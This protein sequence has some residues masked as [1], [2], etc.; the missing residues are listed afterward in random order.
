ISGVSGAG[1]G[2]IINGV[3]K[4]GKFNLA[5]GINVTTRPKEKRDKFDPHFQFVDIVKFK[6]MI[7]KDELLEYDF[8]HHNYYGTNRLIL[9]KLLNNHNILMEA[10]VNGALEIKKKISGVILIYIMVDLEIL[11]KRVKKRDNET[12]EEVEMRMKRAELENCKGLSF[13]YQIENPEGHPE[14]AIKR[15]LKIIK[16]ELQDR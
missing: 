14:A 6:E 5:R 15:V 7:K 3:L 9:E 4:T 12:K 10:D 11:K 1:K 13:D 16:K 8:H 2:T